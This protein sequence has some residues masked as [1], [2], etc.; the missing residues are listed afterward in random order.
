MLF[1][2]A[3]ISAIEEEIDSV[4]GI[5][6]SPALTASGRVFVEGIFNTPA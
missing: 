3:R 1:A 5:E 2:V 6:A 4:R